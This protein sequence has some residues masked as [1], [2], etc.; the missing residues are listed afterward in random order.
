MAID[1]CQLEALVLQIRGGLRARR[2]ISWSFILDRG[3]R[4][5]SS[6]VSVRGS[7]ICDKCPV[8]VIPF[9]QEIINVVD[10]V[11]QRRATPS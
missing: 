5:I 3:V 7:V 10:V 11:R 1:L 9:H 2:W 4:L 8:S 6:S